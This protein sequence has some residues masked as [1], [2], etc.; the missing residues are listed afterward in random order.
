LSNANSQTIKLKALG[1]LILFLVLCFVLTP[2]YASCE[3]DQISVHC[4]KTP[5]ST[6]D[7]HGRL[8]TSFVQ[9]K[10]VYI[11]YSDDKGIQHSSPVK[12]NQTPQTVYANGEN[13]PKIRLDNKGNIFVS[14]TEKTP[15]RFTGDIRFARSTDGGS[16]FEPSIK[17][18]D[19]GLPIGHR[20]DAMTVTPSS[21]I[22][23]AW[24][25][26]RDSAA[27]KESGLDYAGISLYY[28]VSSDHGATFSPNV[29]VAEHTCE[30][31]RIAIAS[32]GESNATVMW[33]HIFSGG[34]R[35]HAIT[36]LTPNGAS[37]ISRATI[38]EWKTDACPHHGPDIDNLS[39]YLTHLTWFSNGALHKGI[40]YG[41][42]QSN[43]NTTTNIIEVD[44]SPQ[45]SHPQVKQFANI[46]WLAW[47][48]YENNQS[49]IKIRKSLNNGALWSKPETI[50]ST[51]GN[52]DHPYLLNDTKNIFLAWQTENEGLRLIPLDEPSV[53][54]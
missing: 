48:T 35:D 47:K 4:G 9:N 1:T 50:V 44:T 42:F 3:Q 46:V 43:L 23:I 37:S 27:A 26:K 40:Y 33:R 24:L 29:K 19:D 30:C 53:R 36:T 14:W 22:Y 18:N 17:I 5:T 7:Q 21:L 25:D 12:V 39:Q 6:F 11:S 13:R 51:L 38:D 28:A 31:C 15:G 41:V 52:S 20:F 49:Y 2:I 32:K 34:M 45:A 10:S 54:Q 16:H 8:W